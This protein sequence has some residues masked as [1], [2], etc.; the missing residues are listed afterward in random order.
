MGEIQVVKTELV[1]DSKVNRVGCIVAEDTDLLD[2]IG[3]GQK[4]RIEKEK[5]DD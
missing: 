3:P 2:Y 1:A 4:Y 5:Q